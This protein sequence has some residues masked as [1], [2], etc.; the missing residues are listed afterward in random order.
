VSLDTLL[1][2]SATCLLSILSFLGVLSLSLSDF[3]SE[4]EEFSCFVGS[5]LSLFVCL[6]VCCLFSF[7]F[8]VCGFGGVVAALVKFSFF[9]RVSVCPAFSGV[10]FE[11]E[12]EEEEEEEERK[13][14]D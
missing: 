4:T 2:L 13:E 1:F 5:S 3:G 9:L 11:V 7:F 6:F 14:E 12:E 8:C 10:S